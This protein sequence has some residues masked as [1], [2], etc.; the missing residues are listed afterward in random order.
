[1]VKCFYH[2]CTFHVYVVCVAMFSK[3]FFSDFDHFKVE[4][5]YFV[6]LLV[7]VEILTLF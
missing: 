5:N 4:P 3:C 6:F 7:N 2:N 1:M